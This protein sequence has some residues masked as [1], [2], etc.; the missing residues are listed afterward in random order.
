[1]PVGTTGAYSPLQ[2]TV[3]NGAGQLT[4]RANTGTP[5]VAPV[6]LDATRTLQR[7]WTLSGGGIRSNITFNYLNGDVPPSPN[8]ENIWNV[9]RVTGNVAIRMAPGANIALNAAANTFTV[10][11]LETYSDWTAGEPL[12]PT[13][14]NASVS[15]RVVDVGGRGISGAQIVMQDQAGNIVWATTNPFGY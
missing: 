5:V 6:P 1:M 14:A 9:I 10:S 13:A 8:D 3:T 2:V 11:N 4:A 12:A 7:Y 15:G